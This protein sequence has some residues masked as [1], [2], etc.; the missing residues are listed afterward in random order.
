METVDWPFE[1]FGFFVNFG[2]LR[3]TARLPPIKIIF[4]QYGLYFLMKRPYM[5]HTDS[6]FLEKVLIYGPSV[7][8]FLEKVLI[9]EPS[10][11]PILEKSFY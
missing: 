10:A 3:F 6:I 1:H 11:N 4:G 2:I 8:L 5:S 7:N 9:Y